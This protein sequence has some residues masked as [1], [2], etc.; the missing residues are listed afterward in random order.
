LSTIEILQRDVVVPTCYVD[1]LPFEHFHPSGK[2]E[3]RSVGDVP[4]GNYPENPEK[5]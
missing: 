3:N 2:M 4:S 1:L 5:E